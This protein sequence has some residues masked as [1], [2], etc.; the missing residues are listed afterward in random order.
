MSVKEMVGEF[1]AFKVCDK[2]FG[3]NSKIAIRETDNL[4]IHAFGRILSMVVPPSCGK[5]SKG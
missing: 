1:P 4:R 2:N 5:A 3:E